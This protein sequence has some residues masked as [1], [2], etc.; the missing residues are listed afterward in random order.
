MKWIDGKYEIIRTLGGGGFSDV[1][2]VKSPDGEV[3]LKLLKTEVTLRPSEKTLI[4]FKNEFNILKNLSHP[5]IARILDFGLDEKL[6]QYY[7]TA[8]HVEGTDTYNS[9]KGKDIATI[10]NLFVQALRA[11]EYLHSY[12][13]F[14]FDIKAGN[15]LVTEDDRLKLIDFGLATIDPKGRLMGTPSYMSPEIVRGEKP[16]GRSDIYSLGVLWY[17][18]LA[19]KNPF[20]SADPKVT[21]E[22][23]K[24]L[25]PPPAS[26]FNANI[27]KYLDQILKRMLEKRPEKRYERASD[28]I[29]DLNIIG[30]L[31]VETETSETLLSYIPEKG[32]FIGRKDEWG[33]I[34]GIISKLKNAESTHSTILISGK[35]GTGKKRFGDEIKYLAQTNEIPVSISDGHNP[36]DTEK[37]LDE[38]DN[39]LRSSENIKAF[40]LHSTDWLE[41]NRS[42]TDRL[43]NILTKVPIYSK[44]AQTLIVISFD[45]ASPLIGGFEALADLHINL[46]NFSRDELREYIINLTGMEEAPDF[47]TEEILKRT[48]GNPLFVTEIAK[49]LIMSG[50]LFDSKGR[51][52]E[53]SFLDLG[54]DF[55]K[56]FPESLK[57]LL[58]DKFY[59]LGKSEKRILEL[60]AVAGRPAN[61]YELSV[62]SEISDVGI[63]IETLLRKDIL[64][65]EAAYS[66]YFR[67]ALMAGYIYDEI[68]E[69]SKEACHDK[70]AAY[71]TGAGGTRDEI[72]MHVGRGSDYRKS[73]DTAFELG[74]DYLKK[75]LGWRAVECFMLASR[76]KNITSQEEE[77]ELNM[78]LGEA[79][80][81]SQN[82]DNALGYFNSASGL[83]TN[84]KEESNVSWR[85]DNLI[86]IGGTYIKAGEL[87]KAGGS[88]ASA[89]ALLGQL[90]DDRTKRLVIENFEG[91]LEFQ[92]GKVDEAV[93][94]YKNTRASW[95]G[96]SGEDKRAVT[97]NELGMVLL[98]KGD[99][100]DAIDILNE[101]LE[102]FN[103]INDELLIARRHYNLAIAYQADGK[104]NEA[105]GHLKMA[106]DISRN[107]KDIEL[108]L[109]TYNGLGNIYNL[110]SEFKESRKYYE[111]ARSLSHQLGDFKNHAAIS[112]NIGSIENKMGD[113]DLAYYELY[114]AI[115]YLKNVQKKSIFDRQ[116]LCRAEMEM[117]EIL[118]KKRDFEQASKSIESTKEIMKEMPADER[119]EFWLLWTESHLHLT[120]G[121]TAFAASAAQRLKEIVKTEEEK[122]SL[123]N[124]IKQIET[125][126]DDM[127]TSYRAILEI[128]KAI[129]SETTLSSV[130]KL[131]LKHSLEIAGAESAAVVLKEPNGELSIAAHKNVSDDDWDAQ[132]SHAFAKEAI[133]SNSIVES[134]NAVDDP[135]FSAEASVKGLNLRSVICMPIRVRGGVIGALYIDSRSEVGAFMDVKKDVLATFTDQI[136]IAINNARRLEELSEK[137]REMES[138]LEDMSSQLKQYEDIMEESVHGFLTKHHYENIIGRSK[139]MSDILQT[140]DKITDTD[141]SVL[142]TG[143]SGT[144]KELIARALHFNSSRKDRKFITINCG[145]IPANLMESELFGY[146]MGAFTGANKDKRGLFEEADGGTIFLDEVTEIEST[147]QVKLLRVL[148]EKEFTRIGDTKPKSCNVRIISA[149]NKDIDKELSEKRFREDLY[150]RLCQIR[151]HIPPLRERRDDI[152]LLTKHFLAKET[153]GVKKISQGLLKSFIEYSWPGNI[154]E[155]ESLVSVISALAENDVIDE[156]CIPGNYGISKYLHSLGGGKSE[157]ATEIRIDEKNFY[158]QSL[159]WKD[160]ENAIY[161]KAYK[162]NDFKVRRAAKE[163]GVVPTTMYA[164]IKALGLDDENNPIYENPFE[165][166]R[167]RELKSYTKPVF[168]AALK[169]AHNRPSKAIS[170]LGISQG[171]F[172]KVIKR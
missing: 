148:Q 23:Q 146:K 125:P 12:R 144:G 85:I 91:Y 127:E 87:D 132:I 4:C 113:A 55:K 169:A 149:T 162:A 67:N 92:E 54:V 98:Q 152:P 172:Y 151:L 138:Q 170:N 159:T 38:I 10:I 44:N 163:L 105:A 42:L 117:A 118:I 7:F 15:L 68:P 69:D 76:N 161:A 40:M 74:D 139:A 60:L 122:I 155:L 27:P 165:Y 129:N 90:K 123:E 78:K 99:H 22:N 111:R 30:N 130:L 45:E 83:L 101:D 6:M 64:G 156:K 1:Y 157:T 41:A 158:H 11:L 20:K 137:G 114:P 57:D 82:Y 47:L 142:I 135:R 147:L 53:A 52:K 150:W 108:L 88:F 134:E 59:D 36:D 133:R 31:G 95:K 110:I 154:R 58:M 18:C 14:H 145:A 89:K 8:E 62:W 56:I 168:N 106:A 25:T 121:E 32:R 63:A 26:S 16:D 97:N 131:I 167:G 75:G 9:T 3:A 124:L 28:I 81:I 80:L 50:A 71:L 2:L 96:L 66:Y 65:R 49:S 136:G 86:K 48:D 39:H 17:Y 24:T 34:T 107:N 109:C 13:I 116:I 120:M 141:I 61:S 33:K 35:L 5:N 126:E 115:L 46:S 19:R 164:K 51:W 93:K 72:V 166:T 153:G 29:K 94:I 43:K 128:N 143:E 112:I 73:F 79:Y 77:I 171:F 84:L 100:N 37:W 119:L 140:T 102:Y 21:I 103:R 160:Y 104:F 70:I